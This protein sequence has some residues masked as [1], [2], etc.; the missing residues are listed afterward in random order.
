VVLV[1]LL[2]A[3]SAR[4]DGGLIGAQSPAFAPPSPPVPAGLQGS[5]T[6]AAPDAASSAADSTASAAATDT[7]GYP[8]ADA[9]C[10]TPGPSGS[11][12]GDNWGYHDPSGTLVGYD[13]QRWRIWNPDTNGYGYRNCTDWVAWRLITLNHYPMPAG[14]G[15]ASNWGG[16]FRGLGFPPNNKPA[17]GAIAWAPR[18]D[19]VAYVEA[20][21][22]DRT[23]VRISEYN[24][25][26]YRGHPTWGYGT[27][28]ERLVPTSAFQYIH[29]RDIVLNSA[30][31]AIAGGTW[32]DRKNG[33]EGTGFLFNPVG[34][35]SGYLVTDLSISGPGGWNGGNPLS[36]AEPY[37]SPTGAG[38]NRALSWDLITPVS[39]IYLANATTNGPIQNQMGITTTNTLG[40]PKITTVSRTKGYISV[41]WTSAS[42]SNSFLVRVNPAPWDGTITAERAL[43]SAARSASFQNLSFTAGRSYQVV[44]WAFSDDI[45]TPGP[46]AR[47][48]NLASDYS[49][50]T[51]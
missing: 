12:I 46:V 14:A 10:A 50:F 15:D 29:V 2:G 26:F 17:V 33:L 41:K 36:I 22:S 27:Y 6:T 31:L 34:Q 43:P 8:W 39:G 30:D 24:E 4:A 38:A 48:F 47:P 45:T 20:V 13:G 11:C 7:G 19:H 18:G 32:I 40:T 5:E 21:S 1:G 51:G 37:Y 28:G 23:Q 3:T 35:T 49:I 16:F 25:T 9:A 44:V 42:G